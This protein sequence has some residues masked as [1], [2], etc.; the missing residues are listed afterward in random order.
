MALHFAWKVTE[1]L[2]FSLDENS[3]G[4]DAQRVIR[5]YLSQ[6]FP[7]PPKPSTR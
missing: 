2:G 5:R 4:S 3:I 7:P 6:H 1:L